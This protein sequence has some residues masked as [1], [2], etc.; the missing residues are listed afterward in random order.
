MQSRLSSSLLLDCIL[1]QERILPYFYPLGHFFLFYKPCYACSCLETVTNCRL[2]WLVRI[3]VIKA[4]IICSHALALNM[5][6]YV[7]KFEDRKQL[8]CLL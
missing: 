6:E 4:K 8:T 5:A 3:L 1:K 7:R 2:V